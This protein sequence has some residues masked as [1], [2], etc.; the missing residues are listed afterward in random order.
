MER[1]R[2]V[3]TGLGAVTPIGHSAPE[4]W[5]SARAGV[6]GVGPI[7]QYDSAGQ[8]VHLAAEV[9]N[10][11]PA[12]ALPGATNAPHAGIPRRKAKVCIDSHLCFLKKS[13]DRRA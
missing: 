2:V 1:R 9:K 6:C 8:K 10:W 7:T 5:R 3:I 4:S 13:P 12:A 11:D